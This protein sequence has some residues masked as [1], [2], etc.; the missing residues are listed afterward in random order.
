M[1]SV[2]SFFNGDLNGIRTSAILY[3]AKEFNFE[4]IFMNNKTKR[5]NFPPRKQIHYDKTSENGKCIRY[6]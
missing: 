4:Y 6:K 2:Q 1:Q 3:S 5:I